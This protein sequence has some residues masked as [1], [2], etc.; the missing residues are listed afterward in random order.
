MENQ[1][2]FDRELEERLL[3]YVRI[4]TQSDEASPTSPS[5][6]KQYDLLNLLVDGAARR[7][8]RRT[9]ALTD[10]GAVL[11][12]IPATVDD[13]RADD[14]LPGP[15]RHGA[16]SS[17]APASSRSSTATTTAATSS[18]PTTR[19]WCCRPTQLP[20]LADKGRRRHRHRQRDDAARRR[21][22]GRRRHRHDHGPPPAAATP[23]SPTARSGSASRR[24]RRSAA[25]STPICRTT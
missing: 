10:Y 15:C 16:R 6:Q 18:C 3:R 23:T 9:C 25:A 13:R 11:A 12:T 17:A 2:A 21:R 8:A 1:S 14:R 4:D 20:Y 24:T 22:Q 5:T 7:S 19:A